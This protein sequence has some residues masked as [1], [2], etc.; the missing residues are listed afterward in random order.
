MSLG[1]AYDP[2]GS[3]EE[4][5]AY[6]DKLYEMGKT[7]WDNADIYGDAEDFVEKWFTHTGRRKEIFLASKFGFV[8]V[9]TGAVSSKGDYAKGSDRKESQKNADRLHRLILPP[10]SQ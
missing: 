1:G 3:D 4:C 6:L 8:D 10:S 5:F 9:T 7:F 2:G